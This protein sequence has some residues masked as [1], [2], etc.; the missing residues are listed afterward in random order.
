MKEMN[1]DDQGVHHCLRHLNLLRRRFMKAIRS[2]GRR[3]G[4]KRRGE[5]ERERER[6]G[7]LQGDAGRIQMETRC[8]RPD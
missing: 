5:R 3:R 4:T 7:E 8:D 2:Q 1:S 6:N